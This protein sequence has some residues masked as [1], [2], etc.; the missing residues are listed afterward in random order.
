MRDSL[1]YSKTPYT[2]GKVKLTIPEPSLILLVGPSGCGKSTFAKKHFKPTEIVSSDHCRA[3]VCDDESNQSASA[4]AFEILNLIASKRLHAGRLTVIDAT[5]VQPE[6]RKPLLAL[7]RKYRVP[8]CAIVL[9]ISEAICLKR[10]QARPERTVGPSVVHTQ[11]RNLR[12][13]L[14][15]LGSEGFD[16][17]YIV[18][19]QKEV[20]AIKI[21]RRPLRRTRS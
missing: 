16:H 19:T 20:D 12:R 2:Q 1:I 14:L 8:P 4:G 17:V 9:N 6:A 3:L 11:S 5:N 13:S 18:S 10:Q 7:A 21:E 15:T